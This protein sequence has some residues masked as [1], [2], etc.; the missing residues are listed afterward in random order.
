MMTNHTRTFTL[1]VA[2]V[3]ALAMAGCGG[4]TRPAGE[5]GWLAGDTHAKFE[6][7]AD[8]FGGID[9]TMMEVG[10][11]YQ[12]LY[13]AGEDGNWALADYQIHELEETLE[14]GFTRR[15]ERRKSAEVFM[16]VALPQLEEAVAMKD[17]AL[18]R[19]RFEALR[20]NCIS[21]HALEDVAFMNVTIPEYRIQPLK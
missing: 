9:Q 1:T 10:Y 8:Q 6:M 13:W 11:R 21:C 20:A 12:V 16:T 4:D 18:F 2:V 15:P 14:R 7:V 19:E 17:Q 3:G 5:G